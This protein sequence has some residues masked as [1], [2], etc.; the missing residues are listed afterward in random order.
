MKSISYS[1]VRL[2]C[3]VLLVAAALE[4]I[5]AASL[6]IDGTYA[7]CPV[8]AQYAVG[9]LLYALALDALFPRK[10]TAALPVRL[11]KARHCLIA[12]LALETLATTVLLLL[13]LAPGPHLLIQGGISFLGGFPSSELWGYLLS[14]ETPATG[15]VTFRYD[16]TLLVLVLVLWAL[17]RELLLPSR[18]KGDHNEGNARKA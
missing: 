15:M 14:G 7:D 6:A 17:E 11:R 5:V 16:G 10:G 4:G 3:G 13:S 12:L 9:Y 2:L 8:Y 1:T 18:R